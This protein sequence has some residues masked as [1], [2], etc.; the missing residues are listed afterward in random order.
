MPSLLVPLIVLAVTKLGLA[1]SFDYICYPNNTI[2]VTNPSPEFYT[3]ILADNSIVTCA[4]KWRDGRR[5]SVEITGCIKDNEIRV[6][7][8]MKPMVD[9]MIIIG[10]A[11]QHFIIHCAEIS[12]NG[13]ERRVINGITSYL[14]TS[15][16]P[17]V[18]P[19]F[20]VHT[21]IYSNSSRTDIVMS[22]AVGT[23]LY[24]TIEGPSEYHL[25]PLVC[26]A[27]SGSNT[28]G[29]MHKDIIINGCS[30]NGDLVGHF[31]VTAPGQLAASLFAFR[32]FNS[33]YVTFQCLVRVCPASSDICN[34]NCSSTNRKKR[35]SQPAANDTSIQQQ[36]VV[37]HLSIVQKDFQL[38]SSLDV[39]ST[40][41]LDVPIVF[42]NIFSIFILSLKFMHMQHA[43]FPVIR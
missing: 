40:T 15:K 35:D 3:S 21:K 11:G 7:F 16:M 32:F 20:R 9:D 18:T 8:M 36:S 14:S 10:D 33:Q 37:T 24:W 27:Y 34:F 2:V 19:S 42:V 5:T 38:E 25:M 29:D 26:T 17:S 4:T 1:Q 31:G 13:V 43:I 41:S 6:S 30:E 28:A 12:L 39:S 23:E 22:A